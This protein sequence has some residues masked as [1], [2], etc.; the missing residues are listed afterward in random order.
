MGR[1][2]LLILCLCTFPGAG[3]GDGGIAVSSREGAAVYAAAKRYLDAEVRRDLPGVYDALAPSSAYRAKY[4]YAAFLAEADSSPVRIVA[5]K[6]VRVDHIRDNHDP[7]AFPGVEKFA[8]VEVDIV[9]LYEDTK[10]RADVNF[11]FTFIR[12]DGKWYKG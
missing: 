7:K 6:I 2:I 10:Q 11:A 9:I 4:D 3:Y 1:V 12:E 5:Y 8:Q